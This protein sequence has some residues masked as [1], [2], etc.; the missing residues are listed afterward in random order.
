M[1]SGEWQWPMWQ[2]LFHGAVRE[3]LAAAS[4]TAL[5]GVQDT[6][7]WESPMTY[8]VDDNQGN[9]AIAEFS[10]GGVIAAMS[11]RALGRPFEWTHAIG[12][13]PPPA[14]GSLRRLCEAPLL[15][16]G[17]GISALFWSV[18]ELI[19]S[20]E[21]WVETW[22]NGA[23]VFEHE[24]LTNPEWKGEGGEYYG[25]TSEVCDL[26]IEVAERAVI[27]TPIARLFRHELTMLIPP[28]SDHE[29]T[30]VDLLTASRLFV[31]G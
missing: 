28:G 29:G 27:G 11:A 30:A 16:E 14:R 8:V 24:L 5:L 10:P 4:S 7:A 18:G 2:G 23:E 6:H 31:V 26:I 21:S 22:S 15:Q 19:Q 9:V 12:T 3:A 1:D 13:A 25:L 17:M 20:A